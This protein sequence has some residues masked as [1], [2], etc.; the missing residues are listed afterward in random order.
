MKLIK[1]LAL[2]LFIVLGGSA[3]YHMYTD[4][5]GVDVAPTT[6]AATDGTTTDGAN[7]VNN[8]DGVDITPMNLDLNAAL[9]PRIL[10]N[11][12]APIK[13]SEHSSFTCSHC[14]K[15]HR[16]TFDGFKS[17]YIDTGKAYMVFSDFP[18]NAPALH[19]SMIGR[20]IDEGQYFS[21]VD[22]LF[23]NQ[24]KWAYDT[25]YL[26]YLKNEALEHG[27]SEADFRSC[28]QNTKLR[29]G[30][31]AN[32]KSVQ[33]QW[34][35]TSTPSFVVNNKTVINGALSV[36][37]FVKK[38]EAAANDAAPVA[39]TTTTTT[40][41]EET[42]TTTQSEM[43]A[44][45]A[46]TAMDELK[47]DIKALDASVK[48]VGSSVVDVTKPAAKNL[49]E[50]AVDAASG[51]KDMA[52]DA[53]EAV[54]DTVSDTLDAVKIDDTALTPMPVLTTPEAS[55]ESLSQ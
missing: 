50:A 38:V 41:T 1:L 12:D 42:T 44:P 33:N 39:T 35:V 23:K 40:T 45:S 54:I 5:N 49:G 17:A 53:K 55:T 25:K 11:T 32:M 10:G 47:A 7:N 4:K 18:L 51:V 9:K 2:I 24:D 26:E 43:P 8:I 31:L 37:E 21:Y 6:V 13:I 16:T 46:P 28:L 20:C 3:L 15:F 19:A 36:D 48:D 22:H 34:D 27:L 30:L 29:E 14:G 52:V